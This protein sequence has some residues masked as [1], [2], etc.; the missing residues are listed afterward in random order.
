MIITLFILQ[1][2]SITIGMI[3]SR[4]QPQ[5]K[6]FANNQNLAN[7]TSQLLNNITGD[8]S[9]ASS[10]YQ[11]QFKNYI[12]P[13][14][15]NEYP[16]APFSA[17]YSN[18]NQIKRSQYQQ[19]YPHINV[20]QAFLDAENDLDNDGQI[21]NDLD[22]QIISKLDNLY[23]DMPKNISTG[24]MSSQISHPSITSPFSQQKRFFSTESYTI[25]PSPTYK[26]PKINSSEYNSLQATATHEAGHALITILIDIY[27]IIQ[28]ATIEF[29]MLDKNGNRIIVS[30]NDSFVT[31]V[32]HLFNAL[33]KKEYTPI[34]GSITVKSTNTNYDEQNRIMNILKS[35]MS[36]NHTKTPNIY[37]I[38]KLNIEAV[39]V[40]AGGTAEQI[41]EHHGGKHYL[42]PEQMIHDQ[43]I[44]QY[45]EQ[46]HFGGD[47]KSLK[48]SILQTFFTF[49]AINDVK[50]KGKNSIYYDEMQKITNKFIIYG[51]KQGYQLLNEYKNELQMI[52]DLLL[53]NGTVS[54]DDIYFALKLHKPLRSTEEGPL[55]EDLKETYF[56]RNK[57]EQQI[58]EDALPNQKFMAIPR[59]Y[60][61]SKAS[62]QNNYGDGSDNLVEID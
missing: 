18:F 26:A 62:T 40:T 27:N 17:N 11:P 4:L 44:L 49:T 29:G 50:T 60:T 30:K 32:R 31:T 51:Y 33:I 56:Y 8:S 35:E 10:N 52:S 15:S 16:K 22:K 53:Q 58:Y 48:E 43:D 46:G 6:R 23:F 55:P 19:K 21:L 39:V 28:K 2:N 54:A 47:I 59:V 13:S 36:S 37:E 57:S 20:E 9:S 34:A 42:A 45:F 41:L 61:Q 24:S 38:Q 5:Y 14:N 12:T 7:A 3:A 25:K 1:I